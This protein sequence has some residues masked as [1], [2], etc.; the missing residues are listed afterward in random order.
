MRIRSRTALAVVA[1]FASLAALVSCGANDQGAG[2]SQ[3][4]AKDYFIS[5]VYPQMHETCG[6]CHATGT[7]G[8]P[9]FLADNA[10]GSYNAIT[11]T[12][13][14][15]G[16]PSA[17]PLVQKGVHSGP[18]LNDTEIDVIP[19]WLTLEVG[20]DGDAPKR[21]TNLRSAF[22]AFGKCMDYNEWV[23]AGLDKLPETTTGSGQC[24][25]C[26]NIGQASLT[27]STDGPA[28]FLAF[29]K[30]PQVQRLVT[31]T[32]ITQCP[33]DATSKT[34]SIGSFKSLVDSHRLIDKGNDKRQLNANHHPVYSL[35]DKVPGTTPADM[36]RKLSDYVAN[37]LDRMNRP[38][39]CA[40]RTLPDAG[41]DAAEGGK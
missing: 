14:L 12:T 27:L 17:S 26:H 36:Q 16:P 7:R 13:G 24:N 3:T 5:K 23:A 4:A 18:A 37:T 9:I 39:A 22:D 6:A 25:S 29:T 21:A 33:P 31:G 35:G 28:T 34:C 19:H 40:T 30:F 10:V 20:A 32:V 1:T 38:N 15:V 11:G 8:A 2:G 41:P